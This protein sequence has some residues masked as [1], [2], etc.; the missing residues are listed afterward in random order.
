MIAEDQSTQVRT[1]DIK[2]MNTWNA[3]KLGSD[4]PPEAS[5]TIAMHGRIGQLRLRDGLFVHYADVVEVETLRFEC[6]HSPGITCAVFLTGG[7]DIAIGDKPLALGSHQQEP[8]GGLASAAVLTRARQDLFLRH[9]LRD[10]RIRK[11]TVTVTP[12]WLDEFGLADAAAHRSVAAFAGRHADCVHYRPS[13]RIARLVEDMLR[14]TA[15][16]GSLAALRLESRALDLVAEAFE[17]IALEG[18][19]C[20][21]RGARD[22]DRRR[23]ARVV[24]FIEAHLDQPLDLTGLA[25]EGALSINTLQRL[26]RATFNTTVLDYVRTRR[27][28][29]AHDALR[30]EGI[31]VAQ[32]AFLAG[33]SSPANFIPAFKR[34]FGLTPAAVRTALRGRA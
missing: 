15:L 18:P 33:Y 16:V 25:R 4:P 3:S 21:P 29:R 9:T 13:A 20:E 27:L 19:A 12:E 14:P 6:A 34:A 22:I 26:F 10:E 11:V 5:D 28:E 32:A 7:A 24:D 30:D 1:S 23:L 2:A 17:A 31:S 8:T